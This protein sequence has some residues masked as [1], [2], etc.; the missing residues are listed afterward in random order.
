MKDAEQPKFI[1]LRCHSEYSVTDGIVKLEE[2]LNQALE[3]DMPALA[4]TDLSNLFGAVK[5]YKKAI[6]KKIKPIIGCDVWVQNEKNR[7]Q[8]YRILVLCQSQEGYLNLSR[9]ISKS[10][11]E[12]QYKGRAEVKSEWLLEDFNKGLIILSGALQ[13]EIGQL[14]LNDKAKE[15]SEIALKWQE[16]FGDRFYLELQ[17]YAEGKLLEDQERYIQQALHLASQ[18]EI[19]VVA[20]HP[21][22]FMQ[23]DDFRAHETKTCIAEGYV[24]A[25]SRRPKTFSPNQFF[26]DGEAM[27]DLFKDIPSAIEN[28]LEIAKRCNFSFHL[29]DTYLPNFPIPEGMN[30]DEFLKSEAEKGLKQRLES[31]PDQDAIDEKVYFDRLNFEVDVINQMGFPGY[32]LIVADFIQWSKDENIPVGPGRGSGAGSIVAWALK[33]TDLDPIR[34]GLLFERF[35]NP[36]RVSMPDFDID[37][38]QDRRDE[39]IRYV[40]DKYGAPQVAQIITF[41]KLQARA[42]LRASQYPSF[43]PPPN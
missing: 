32:F 29:G 12:N 18:N 1:H 8:P 37:F 30:I 41:G 26:K 34:Y 25:D 9:L 22:Q 2:Y 42:V 33:I 36:E 39:V 6:D 19:P 5:F 14:I 21:I 13:G 31:F 17:R 43:S 27:A 3:V 16:K 38:C 28:S 23:A 10:F 35:L 40:A 20:T 11:L 4:L 24:L 7:E 15:A